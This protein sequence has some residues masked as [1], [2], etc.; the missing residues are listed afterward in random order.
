MEI[1]ITD[2]VSWQ[3]E[4]GA[5]QSEAAREWLRTEIYGRLA[6]NT[7]EMDRVIPT[8]DRWG[9]PLEWVVEGVT[10]RATVRREYVDAQRPTWARKRDT[11]TVEVKGGEV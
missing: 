8:V 2:G 5:Q 3:T 9:R 1:K 7:G 4:P 11:V 6:M 10:W